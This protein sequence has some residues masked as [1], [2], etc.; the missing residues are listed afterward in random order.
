MSAISKEPVQ[1]DPIYDP[2]DPALMADPYPY[3]ERLREAHPVYYNERM[4]FYVLS[5]YDDIYGALRKPHL[6]SSAQG[7]TPE[8]DEI[9]KLGLPPTFIMMD[10]PEHTRLRRLITHGYGG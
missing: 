9:A 5:R 8:K 4:D 10:P 1:Y 3:Y 6:F 7:L 2:F